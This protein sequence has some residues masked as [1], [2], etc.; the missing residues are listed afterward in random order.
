R[1]RQ[2]NVNCSFRRIP[3]LERLPSWRLA[4]T[5][6]RRHRA[7]ACTGLRQRSSC[8]RHHRLL[9]GGRRLY[10]D[11]GGSSQNDLLSYC[12]ARNP[13]GGKPRSSGE[14]AIP[15]EEA[16]A[17]SMK[18]QSMRA[19]LP[20]LIIVGAALADESFSLPSAERP[21]WVGQCVARLER[22]RAQ[23]ARRN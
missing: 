23:A 12:A 20:I 3:V 5:D 10:A 15:C 6:W 7:A 13:L 22:A 16:L 9:F 19:L 2:S 18:R 8:R 1:K 4:R 17:W 14:S 11:H 21:R